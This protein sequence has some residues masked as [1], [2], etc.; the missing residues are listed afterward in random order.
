MALSR[1]SSGQE[2][3]CTCLRSPGSALQQRWGGLPGE[4]LPK[5]WRHSWRR[6]PSH[7]PCPSRPG[8]GKRAGLTREQVVAQ[9]AVELVFQGEEEG[10]LLGRHRLA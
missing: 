8:G 7:H 1:F 4:T 5:I 9:L 3:S 2:G 6:C 10:Q